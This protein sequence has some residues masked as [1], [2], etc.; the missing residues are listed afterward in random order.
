M[1][2]E[3]ARFDSLST[4]VSYLV[5]HFP[6]DRVILLNEHPAPKF[7]FRG[8]AK[9]YPTTESHQVRVQS[10]PG[11]RES[12]RREIL[13][14]ADSLA[15]FLQDEF[16]DQPKAFGTPSC[17]AA[18]FLQHYGLPTPFIDF[19]ASIETAAFFATDGEINQM[20]TVA[21]IESARAAQIGS[22]Y[23]L[24]DHPWAER[25]RRQS[26]YAFAPLKFHD[27]KSERAIMELGILWFPFVRRETDLEALTVKQR[28][29]LDLRNDPVAGLLRHA[30]N[31]Y[32]AEL[33]KLDH[34]VAEW[35]A[36]RIPMVPLSARVL[37]Q[38]GPGLPKDMEF[39]QPGIPFDEETERQRS[40]Q[41]WS[42]NFPE[43]LLAPSYMQSGSVESDRT[44]RFPAT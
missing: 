12:D 8:E 44:Y 6:D 33:G 5:E 39:T 28:P 4:C 29:L 3:P 18:H 11:L 37:S 38:Y 40:I 27:L 35:M 2:G 42:Q 36:S 34:T 10:D 16:D 41:L 13:K 7:L 25:A 31:Q 15:T 1:A 14:I 30:M 19:T 43:I 26:A 21:V 9:C 17:L 20:G 23:N 22:L 24:E 32:V